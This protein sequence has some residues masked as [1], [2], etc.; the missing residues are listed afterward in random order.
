MGRGP[1]EAQWK[2][3]IKKDWEIKNLGKVLNLRK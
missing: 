2:V 3:V 1:K